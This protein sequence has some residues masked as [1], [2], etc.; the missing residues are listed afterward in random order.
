[1]LELDVRF[2]EISPGAADWLSMF[3][4]ISLCHPIMLCE[5]EEAVVLGLISAN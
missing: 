4:Y 2:Q 1:M 3:T 5:E